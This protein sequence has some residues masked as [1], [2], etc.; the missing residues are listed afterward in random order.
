MTYKFLAIMSLSLSFLAACTSQPVPSAQWTCRNVATE[1]SCLDGECTLALE[2]GF[3]P[4]ELTLASDGEMS[5]CAYSG[6]WAG[7]GTEIITAG[8]YF[9]AIGLNLPWSGTTD[10]SADMSATINMKTMI[11]TVLTAGYAHPMTC[12]A[13]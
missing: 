13:L 12:A 7:K 3:T 11:A 6:C 10:G 4:M 5:L 1:I 9:T 2:G 8:N